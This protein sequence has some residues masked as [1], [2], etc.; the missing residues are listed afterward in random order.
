MVPG[1]LPDGDRTAHEEGDRLGRRTGSNV[2]AGVAGC[3]LDPAG[4]V[5]TVAGADLQS[6]VAER[7]TSA[8]DASSVTCKD[9]LVGAVGQTVRCVVVMSPTNSFEPIVTVTGVNG[10]TI[11]Y[12]MTPALSEEQLERAVARLVSVNG[13]APSDSVVCLSGLMGVIGAVARCDVTTA[14]VTLQRTAAV[15][16]VEGLM[17][18]LRP[19]PG[20]DEDR[21]GGV[22]PRRTHRTSGQ[23]PG[24]RG[25]RGQPRGSTGGDRR[26]H[27]GRRTG[28]RG[29]HTDGHRR[30]RHQDRLQL[31]AARLRWVRG[32]GVFL[33]S[34]CSMAAG[35]GVSGIIP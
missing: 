18:Q 27:R 14:G 8:G 35:F 23:A 34:S 19:D 25:M 2:L 6:D 4:A 22:A 5:A 29:L 24:L 9:D 31:R 32:T 1:K 28:Q 16:S 3:T 12:E 26:L 30:G 33:G 15:T 20:A 17:M 21:G 13:G 7:L 11:N 10:A